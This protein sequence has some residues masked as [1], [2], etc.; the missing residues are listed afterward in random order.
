MWDNVDATFVFCLTTVDARC[1]RRQHLPS[2]HPSQGMRWERAKWPNS[3]AHRWLKLTSVPLWNFILI[4]MTQFTLSTLWHAVNLISNSFQNFFYVRKL[5]CLSTDWLLVD[6][7]AWR[8]EA[9][10]WG[11]APDQWWGISCDPSGVKSFLPWE[12]VFYFTLSQPRRSGRRS[13]EL[14]TQ[15]DSQQVFLLVLF[16]K[17]CRVAQLSKS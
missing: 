9:S 2:T 1:R 3:P 14:A 11:T 13:G 10:V 5:M 8:K 7:G 16:L 17:S 12:F 15:E 6:T 4:Y